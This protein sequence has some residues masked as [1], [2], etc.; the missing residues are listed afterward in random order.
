MLSLPDNEVA[1]LGK[2]TGKPTEVVTMG[3]TKL[4]TLPL[5]AGMAAGEMPGKLYDAKEKRWTSTVAVS[6]YQ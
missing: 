3:K 4:L 5:E 2:K 1:E 6:R